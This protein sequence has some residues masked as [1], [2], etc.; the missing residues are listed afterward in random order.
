MFGK[1]FP[2]NLGP[3]LTFCLFGLLMV[4]QLVLYLKNQPELLEE[5]SS[6]TKVLQLKAE[7]LV[8]GKEMN[9]IMAMKLHYLAC[10]L[11]KAGRWHKDLD[12]KE[13]IDGLIK[14]YVPY[15]CSC[16]EFCHN[17]SPPNV[18]LRVAHKSKS[19]KKNLDYLLALVTHE[20]VPMCKMCFGGM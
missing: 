1:A 15:I 13:G 17:I 3:P 19:S 14:Q 11:K 4:C 8:K 18:H 20:I 10:V 6:A 16:S 7:S 12:G 5:Y 2:W 9:E